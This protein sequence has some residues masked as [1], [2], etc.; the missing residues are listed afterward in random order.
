LP[1]LLDSVDRA[2]ETYAHVRNGGGAA[3]QEASLSALRQRHL[4][5]LWGLR[6]SRWQH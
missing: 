3:A 6:L 5:F 4:V 1:R 2:R